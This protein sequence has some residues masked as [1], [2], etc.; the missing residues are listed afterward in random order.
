[1][2]M[3][4]AGRAPARVEGVPPEGDGAPKDANLWRPHP[5]PDTAGASRRANHGGYGSGPRFSL[6]VALSAFGLLERE[7]NSQPAPG[8]DS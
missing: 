4:L 2:P 8:G 3:R 1:M 6:F 5:L 7:N